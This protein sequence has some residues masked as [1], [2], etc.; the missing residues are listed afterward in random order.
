[1]YGSFIATF[2]PVIIFRISL[3]NVMM[4]PPATVRNP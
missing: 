3:V 1:M 4:I 2:Y